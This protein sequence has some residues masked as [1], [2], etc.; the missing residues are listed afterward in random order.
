M[1]SSVHRPIASRL[2]KAAAYVGIALAAAQVSAATAF[3]ALERSALQV[4]SPERTALLS[5]AHAGGRLVAVG[6]RGVIA[7]SDDG[8][9]TWRQAK[10]VPVAVTLTA[11]QFIDAYRGWAV[12][13]GGAVLASDDGGETWRKL[14]DGRNL[15]AVAMQ[16]ARE[17][18]QSTPA[19]A[20]A[21]TVLSAAEAL[22]ADGPD[23]PLFDVHFVDARHGWVIG[24]YNLFFETTDGGATWRSLMGRLD[25]RGAKHLYSMAVQGDAFLIAGEQGT[26]FRSDD[27]GASFKRSATGYNGSWFKLVLLKDQRIIVAGLRGNAMFSVDRGNTWSRIE[28]A[29]PVTFVG[30]MA[31]PD[32]SALLCNQAGQLLQSRDGARLV[33]FSAPALTLPVD[34]IAT[35]PQSLLVIGMTGATRIPMGR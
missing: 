10:S 2:L 23:K 15:A 5:A 11:V 35:S 34:V 31:L 20:G 29:P 21:K 3:P 4:R 8:G 26:L 24:A 13:H 16:D 22:V 18:A 33:P 19:D 14:A 9:A 25:N 30:G 7:L 12:G 17:R 6:E 28:G 1:N 32:G 27:A